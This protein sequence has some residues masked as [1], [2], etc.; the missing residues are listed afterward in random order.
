MTVR[1]RTRWAVAN[2]GAASTD[3]NEPSAHLWN[4]SASVTLEVV[5]LSIGH[6]SALAAATTRLTRTSTTGTGLPGQKYQ[7]TQFNAF[8]Q[9]AVNPSG[10]FL[11]MANFSANPT[12]IVSD[13]WRIKW[14]D[15]GANNL[16]QRR[17]D[18]RH[19]LEVPPGTGLAWWIDVISNN[20]SAVFEWYE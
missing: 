7:P 19:P 12:E 15:P 5:Y 10:A 11:Q 14:V 3:A 20:W 1:A 8:D 2:A 13:L 6:Q 18:R 9:S 4:P 16:V 17:L